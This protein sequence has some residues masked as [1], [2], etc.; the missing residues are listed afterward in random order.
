MELANQ[1]RGVPGEPDIAGLVLR[2]SMRTGERRLH[3]VFPDRAGLGIEPAKLVG[4][5]A[6]PPDRAVARGQ[7][8]VRSRTL[9]RNIPHQ[10][11]RLRWTVED[12]GLRTPPFRE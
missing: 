12:G 5:L 6:G 3:G 9:R 1:A 8:I 4:E 10:A 7:R 11:I 2:Q